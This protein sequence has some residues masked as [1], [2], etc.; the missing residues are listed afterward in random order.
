[1]ITLTLKNED[2]F[3]FAYCLINSSFAYWWWRIFDGGI[4]Y[5]VG[6]LH[7]LPTFLDLLSK[8]DID[9]FKN[10]CKDMIN[11]EKKCIVT[12][13]NAGA[14]QENIKFPSAYRE[15]INRKLLDLLGFNNFNTENF[16]NI[17]KNNFFGD[18]NDN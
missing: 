15:K 17:H 9:F 4:T 10:T 12:K 7:K 3:N 5:G 11:N 14:P 6:L 1:M 8:E 13:M 18:T 2:V 16:D